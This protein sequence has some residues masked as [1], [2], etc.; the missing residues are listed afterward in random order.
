MVFDIDKVISWQIV[1]KMCN[2]PPNEFPLHQLLTYLDIYIPRLDVQ[3]VYTKTGQYN[4]LVYARTTE[5]SVQEVIGFDSK[6][7]KVNH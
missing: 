5:L 4:L 2:F 3:G 6:M 1:T 7:Y